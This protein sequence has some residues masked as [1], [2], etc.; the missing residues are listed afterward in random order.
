[1][2]DD[3]D[4][5]SQV[6]NETGGR[7]TIYHSNAGAGTN[8]LFVKYDTYN[9]TSD[10]WTN[11]TNCELADPQGDKAEF[12]VLAHSENLLTAVA[13]DQTNST[14]LLTWTCDIDVGGCDAAADWTTD[15]TD[16]TGAVSAPQIV[17]AADHA[18][19][20]WEYGG[21]I[22][23][24]AKCFGETAFTIRGWAMRLTGVN[25]YAFA[26]VPGN[27]LRV[28]TANDETQDLQAV[29]LGRMGSSGQWDPIRWH[30]GFSDVCP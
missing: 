20:L 24:A 3:D 26:P 7:Y 10:T 9:G 16:V 8:N 22:V 19:A 2:A 28:F 25:E 27:S 21:D 6:I 15:R 5:C 23:V 12:P 14:Y 17:L 30:A 4:H 11:H 18:F 1:M 13:A 29:F